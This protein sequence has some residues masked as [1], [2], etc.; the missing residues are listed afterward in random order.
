MATKGDRLHFVNRLRMPFRHSAFPAEI[1]S[2]GLPVKDRAC[3]RSQPL[4]TYPAGKVAGVRGLFLA[5]PDISFR[6][7]PPC[8]RGPAGCGCGK[9]GRRGQTRRQPH[10]QP[11]EGRSRKGHP[12]RCGAETPNWGSQPVCQTVMQ[13]IWGREVEQR[14]IHFHFC[15]ATR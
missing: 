6:T 13:Q 15:A 8:R 10:R 11:V 1:P 14:A 9:S 5:T 7:G 4:L 12:A 2:T 3:R